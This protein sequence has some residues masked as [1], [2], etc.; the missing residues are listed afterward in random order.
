MNEQ[1]KQKILLVSIF[2]IPAS[3]KSSLIKYISTYFSNNDNYK[4][5]NVHI[6]KFDT[7]LHNILANYDKFEPKLWHKARISMF[8]VK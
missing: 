4:N 3:G 7:I 6:I 1:N 2:G 8:I 5:I